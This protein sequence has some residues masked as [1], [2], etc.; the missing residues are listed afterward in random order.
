MGSQGS[1]KVIVSVRMG[2]Y[3]YEQESGSLIVK[4]CMYRRESR[5]VLVWMPVYYTM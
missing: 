3:W 5:C 1:I 2:V 4:C